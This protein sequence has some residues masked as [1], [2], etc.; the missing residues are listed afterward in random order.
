[1]GQQTRSRSAAFN[2]SRRQG[3]LSEGLANRASHARSNNPVH[4]KAT[5]NIFEFFGDVFANGLQTAAT[6]PAFYARRQ[7]LVMARQM[8]W[9][10]FAAVLAR[11]FVVLFE[12]LVSR[13]RRRF[14]DLL[15]FLE[16]QVS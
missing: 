1:M 7:N 2:R 9:Q 12:R 6:D 8:I 13:L 15:I 4:D 5:R 16:R 14:R 10:G 11:R 3:R